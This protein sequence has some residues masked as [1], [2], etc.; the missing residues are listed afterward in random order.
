MERMIKKLRATGLHD[1]IVSVLE[2]WLRARSAKVVVSRRRISRGEVVVEELEVP[3]HA[4]PLGELEQ[5]PLL[6]ASARDVALGVRKV[7]E[8]AHKRLLVL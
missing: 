3:R 1:K 5:A 8:D 7:M 4:H 2:S 6:G